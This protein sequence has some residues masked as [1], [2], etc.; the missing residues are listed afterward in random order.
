[1][2]DKAIRIGAQWD[3][4]TPLWAFVQDWRYRPA[5]HWR[6][7]FGCGYSAKEIQWFL[8]GKGIRVWG[9]LVIGDDILFSTRKAQGKY[10]AYW[11]GRLCVPFE[12]G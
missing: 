6:V 10:T 2:F 8:Q 3:W 11:L 5:V 7:P 1:M 9:L 12:G 4:I